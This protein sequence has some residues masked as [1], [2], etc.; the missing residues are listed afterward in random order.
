MSEVRAPSAQA[1]IEVHAREIARSGGAPGIR[2]NGGIEAALAR[3]DHLR[4][5]APAEPS[6]FELA[7][8]LAFSIARQ[9]PFIDGNKRV[10]LAAVWFTLGLN[11]WHLDT[12][13]RDA[14]A[15]FLKVADGSLDEPMLADCLKNNA[16]RR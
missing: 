15:M 10:A 4:A 5:Y 7:A 16:I 14:A 2:D 12:A 6:V 8:A 3:L 13:E 11:G 9:H 1:L